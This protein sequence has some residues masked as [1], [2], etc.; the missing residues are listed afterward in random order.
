[1]GL[2]LWPILWV[3]LMLGMLIAVVVTAVIEKQQ[4]AKAAK[5]LRANQAQIPMSDLPGEEPAQPAGDDG[6]G[7]GSEAEFAD[8]DENAF[9]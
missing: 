5:D 7:F 1:M 2:L 3:T 6:F 9:K 4:R 8:F